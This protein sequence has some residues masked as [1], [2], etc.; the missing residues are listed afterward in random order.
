LLVPSFKAYAD[1]TLG[2]VLA[3]LPILTL[4]FGVMSCKPLEGLQQVLLLLLQERLAVKMPA[5]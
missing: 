1:S 4:C 2:H 3:L 5:S